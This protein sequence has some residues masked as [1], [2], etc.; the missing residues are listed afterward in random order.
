MRD[1][2]DNRVEQQ[3]QAKLHKG[4]AGGITTPYQRI[5]VSPNKVRFRQLSSFIPACP[6]SSNFPHWA[7]KLPY[8]L[9]AILF[10]ANDSDSDYEATN[11]NISNPISGMNVDPDKN[12]SSVIK[13]AGKFKIFILFLYLYNSNGIYFL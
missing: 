2:I 6:T 11:Q 13:F 8:D 1:I 10:N 3:R 4:S 9:N 7:I 5:P 12:N